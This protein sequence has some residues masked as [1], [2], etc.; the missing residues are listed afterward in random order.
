M[1]IVVLLAGMLLIFATTLIDTVGTESSSASH[2]VVQ[3]TAFQAAEAGIED[4]I[5][6][7]TD[8]HLY[9]AHFVHPGEAT[10]K[11]GANPNVGP[12]VAWTYSTNPPWTYPNGK[13]TWYSGGSQNPLANGYQYDLEITAPSAAQ[14][15]IQ[16]ISTGRKTGS[17]T[18]ERVLQVL[19]RPSSVSDFQ[20]FSKTN[21]NYGSTATTYGKVYAGGSITHAGTAYGDLYA[22]GSI[23]GGVTMLSGAKQYTPSTTPSI[24]T[25]I[26]SPVNYDDFLTSISDISRAASAGGLYLGG[27]AGS[28]LAYKLT[29]LSSGSLTWATCTQGATSDVVA[30]SPTCGATTTVAVPSNGAIYVDRDVIVQGTLNGRVTVASA[31]D[32]VVAADISYSDGHCANQS[33]AADDVLG[34][35][36]NNNVLIAGWSPTSI[37]WC[38][39][40]IAQNGTW[41]C[42]R[43]SVSSA[44]GNCPSG[45]SNHDTM[46]FTGSAAV[47]VSG[48]FSGMYDTRNY[49]YDNALLYLLPPWF[50]SVNDSYTTSLFRELTPP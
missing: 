24:R 17:T 11:S 27:A 28:V 36:A 35:D 42:S 3:Q 29:F 21:A 6:K 38:A 50:P 14:P 44:P 33:L 47:T 49:Y 48:N 22:E 40:V 18:D 16:I 7:L 41:G 46:T 43:G 9:Y 8:D 25:I 32:I 20:F 19:V 2:A 45:T 39:A 4:Y 23:S 1:V 34:L 5:S 31:D 12:G 30:S 37:N 15:S 10:R 26:K 13:D